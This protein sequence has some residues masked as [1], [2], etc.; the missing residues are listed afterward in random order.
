MNALYVVA[1]EWEEGNGSPG[2]GVKGGCELADM[3]AYEWPY[4][5]L[6]L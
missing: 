4:L 1:V 6:K 2:A 5:E 3:G